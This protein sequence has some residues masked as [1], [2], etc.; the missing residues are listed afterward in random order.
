MTESNVSVL[1]ASELEV[2]YPGT[3]RRLPP[4]CAID[5]R[6]LVPGASRALVGESGSG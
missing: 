5:R 2:R 1:L 6:E 3:D 4:A